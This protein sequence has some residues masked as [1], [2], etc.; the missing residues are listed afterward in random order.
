MTHV[1]RVTRD[2]R[3]RASRRRASYDVT[4]IVG[5][6]PLSEGIRHTRI[7]NISLKLLAVGVATLLFAVSR[8]PTS[9]VGLEHVPL[10]FRG[11]AQGLEITG[12]VDQTVSVRLR[13]PRDVVR[14]LMPNQIAVVADISGKERATRSSSCK[15]SF[16]CLDP[17]KP[18]RFVRIRSRDHTSDHR[19]ERA[20]IG[21]V[22]AGANRTSCKWLRGLSDRYSTASCRNRRTE[23]SGERDR[24]RAN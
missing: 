4:G 14:G 16:R 17:P 5:E 2:D 24:C 10:E 12:E 23:I 15:K 6:R 8:Q 11:V 9:D 20:T 13:G 21:A 22:E 1:T 3:A 18:R 7:E 19:A